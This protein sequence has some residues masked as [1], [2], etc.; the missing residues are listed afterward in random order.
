VVLVAVV[1]GLLV[2][3]GGGREKNKNSDADR[4]RP[5]IR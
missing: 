1:C 4:P 5:S 2:G 3:C